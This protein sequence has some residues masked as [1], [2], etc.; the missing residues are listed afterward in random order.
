MK[1]DYLTMCSRCE[2]R[3]HPDD[4]KKHKKHCNPAIEYVPYPIYPAYHPLWPNLPYPSWP[5]WTS[6]TI[7]VGDTTTSGGTAGSD[8]TTATTT[9]ALSS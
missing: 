5:T 6:G 4:Y 2:V 1:V 9:Y 3:M 8:W 7:T